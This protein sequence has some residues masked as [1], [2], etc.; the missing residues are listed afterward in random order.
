MI[1]PPQRLRLL[2]VM[3]NVSECLDS[4]LT[5]NV[6]KT[7][8]IYF[9]I[10][11]KQQVYPD[12]LI[13]GQK[14]KTVIELKYLPLNLK[15]HVTNTIKTSLANFQLIRNSCYVK[16][17]SHVWSQACETSLKPLKSVYKALKILYK[18]MQ[19]YPTAIYSLSSNC[20]DS[21]TFCSQINCLVYNITHYLISSEGFCTFLLQEK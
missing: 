16:V 20:L 2:E 7:V 12:I 18:K 10:K 5:L 15:K 11:Q 13:H 14:I 8:A 3:K 1:P 17:F 21:T 19:H 6:V 9:S 4:F